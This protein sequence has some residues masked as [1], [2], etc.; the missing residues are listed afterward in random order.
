MNLDAAL[1]IAGSGL[2]N[3]NAQLA[4]VSHNVANASTAG[5]AVETGNQQELTVG[6]LGMGVVTGPATRSIDAELQADL[7]AT[8]RHGRGLADH[9]DRARLDRRGER[10]ARPGQRSRQSAGTTC[11]T[12]SQLC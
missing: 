2:A 5:Y 8:E 4:L 12:S 11:K 1:S 9:A 7:L 3:V 6:G 10:H